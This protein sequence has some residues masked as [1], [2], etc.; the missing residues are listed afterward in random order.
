MVKAKWWWIALSVC[1]SA[2]GGCSGAGESDEVLA[3]DFEDAAA[4]EGSSEAA[5]ESV[6]KQ[7][8]ALFNLCEN[9]R[10]E[11]TN[12]FEEDNGA[13]PDIKVTA[14]S[15]YNSRRGT[16]SKQS[17]SNEII[18]YNDDYPYIEDLENSDGDTITRWR[19]YHKHDLGNG[20]GNEV[21]QEINTA[22]RTCTDGMTVELTVTT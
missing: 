4:A 2:L 20:W 7:Q 22:D 21:Y 11:V 16:W 9:V 19:V 18:G 10:V 12:L 15:F 3:A 14:L 1:A 8:Q 17:V 5:T 6:G 13:R